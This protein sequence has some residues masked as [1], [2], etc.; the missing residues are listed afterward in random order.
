MRGCW[1]VPNTILQFSHR[2]E[3]SERRAGI[4]TAHY[5]MRVSRELSDTEVKSRQMRLGCTIKLTCL[6]P[7][8]LSRVLEWAEPTG[9]SNWTAMPRLQGAAGLIDC[10]DING[11]SCGY[12]DAQSRTKND[13]I[14]M[15][16]DGL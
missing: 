3:T 8:W 7:L 15:Q 5:D 12:G 14:S 4:M 11:G 2:P 6:D 16:H 9:S 10:F 13:G 1:Q